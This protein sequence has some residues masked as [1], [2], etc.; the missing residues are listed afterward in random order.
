M[1]SQQIHGQ[2]L[3]VLNSLVVAT[4]LGNDCQLVQ[5]GGL[6]RSYAKAKRWSGNSREGMAAKVLA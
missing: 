2:I 3:S 5:K 4:S 6:R 1:R